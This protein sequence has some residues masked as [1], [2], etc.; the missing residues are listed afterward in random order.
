M[1]PYSV[2][3]NDK[4][5]YTF[6][7]LFIGSYF[8][9]SDLNLLVKHRFLKCENAQYA[10]LIHALRKLSWKFYE[11]CFHHKYLGW[12]SFSAILKG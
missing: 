3:M 4:L 8:S 6:A 5:K 1:L 12:F 2:F 9:N 11:K 7:L 10:K